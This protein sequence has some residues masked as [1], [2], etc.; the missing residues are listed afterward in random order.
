MRWT[1]LFFSSVT[2]FRSDFEMEKQAT[3]E[4]KELS[5]KM[6]HLATAQQLDFFF[7]FFKLLKII[8]VNFSPEKSIN[9]LYLFCT[10]KRYNQQGGVLNLFFSENRLFYTSFVYCNV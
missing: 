9:L 8:S 2:T 3:A 4:R 5:L 1:S 7:V 6:P 10:Q